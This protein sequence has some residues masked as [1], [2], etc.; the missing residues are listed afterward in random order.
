MRD[1]GHDCKFPGVVHDL[2]Y[3]VNQDLPRVMCT[4]K[5]EILYMNK[6]IK[7]VRY[8]WVKNSIL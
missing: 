1:W 6:M 3:I 7:Y 4:T 2:F 5:E 8:F